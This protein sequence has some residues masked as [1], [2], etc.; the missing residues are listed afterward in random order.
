MSWRKSTYYPPIK[1]ALTLLFFLFVYTG[2]AQTQT[3]LNNQ[4]LLLEK[5]IAYT[6]ELLNTTLKSKDDS[7]YKIELLARQI[8]RHEKVLGSIQ[9]EIDNISHD[10]DSKQLEI[11][12]KQAEL[13]ALKEEYAKMIYFANRNRENYDKL[14]FL[15]SSK[16]FNQAY[17]RLK[18]F[19]QYSHYRKNQVKLINERQE[20]LDKDI[21]QLEKNKAEK[22]SLRLKETQ[23]KE[24]LNQQKIE[25]QR[26]LNRLK[27]KENGLKSDLR[28]KER[29]KDAL[30]KAIAKLIANEAEKTKKFAL[31]PEELSI[32]GDFENNQGKLPWPVERGVLFSSFGE[33][34]HPY[35]KGIK[36]RNDGI[37]IATDEGSQARAIFDGEVRSII[38]VPG[39]PNYAILIKHG[40]YFT[41]YSNITKA[42]VSPGQKVKARQNLGEI[43]KEPSDQSTK[44]QFQLWK[45]TT[46]LNP[47]NWLSK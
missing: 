19:E 42:I 10:I 4:I 33:H 34:A 31:T 16:D 37:D 15:F 9:K 41:L 12:K 18:Y 44:L 17:K 20:A 3:E 14:M 11:R 24:K 26:S 27:S 29:Q 8:S 23:T 35:I 36:I 46:K 21:K 13:A 32:S 40:N 43:Y 30:K 25:Q 7:Y 47:I 28:K 45:N 6:N 38:S 22:L 39:T 2:F 5:E 1:S